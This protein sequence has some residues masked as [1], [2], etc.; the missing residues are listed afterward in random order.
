MNDAI[1]QSIVVGAVAI[2]SAFIGG[3]LPNKIQSKT[4]EKKIKCKKLEELYINIENWYNTVFNYMC[5]ELSLV[6]D[7]HID[8]NE[9]LD[10]FIQQ[11]K[12]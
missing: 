10:R 8:W 1:I 9:Y 4:K 6:F 3:I 11:K 7:G 2:L 5:A 12:R